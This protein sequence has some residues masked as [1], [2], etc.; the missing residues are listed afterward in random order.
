MVKKAS[1]PKPKTCR[2]LLLP[3]NEM[4]CNCRARRKAKFCERRSKYI[5][6]N[7]YDLFFFFMNSCI[8]KHIA[9]IIPR[10]PVKCSPRKLRQR[11]ER[12]ISASELAA[13]AFEKDFDSAN[14]SPHI[15]FKRT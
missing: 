5:Y 9:D 8:C 11:H 3:V 6:F 10:S 12:E 7:M 15:Q 4:C 2:G 14:P 1:M 13:I